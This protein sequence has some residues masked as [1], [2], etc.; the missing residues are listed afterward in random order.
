MTT[1]VHGEHN[2]RAVELASQALFGK[3]EL[4]ELDEST[5]AAALKEASVS[6][7]APGGSRARSSICS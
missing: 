3:A 7:L 2:T 4:A 6:E 1:L 5:L